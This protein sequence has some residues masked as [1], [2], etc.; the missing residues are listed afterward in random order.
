MHKYENNIKMNLKKY[1]AGAW[2][3]FIWHG[4]AFSGWLF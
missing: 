4:I 2:I 1:H 3:R